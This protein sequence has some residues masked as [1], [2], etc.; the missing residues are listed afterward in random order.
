MDPIVEEEE[1]EYTEWDDFE[2]YV[3]PT[4]TGTWGTEVKYVLETGLSYLLAFYKKS[5]KEEHK[6]IYATVSEI[7]ESEKLV[8]LMD[9]D[10]NE[11]IF[12]YTEEDDTKYVVTENDIYVITEMYLVVPF[13][14]DKEDYKVDDEIDLVVSI[15]QEK[16]Y[17]DYIQ[18]DDISSSLIHSLDVYDQ[19]IRVKEIRETA[20]I[21]LELSKASDTLGIHDSLIITDL[22]H[23]PKC[24]HP[25]TNAFLKDYDDDNVLLSE[26]QDEDKGTYRETIS[27][28]YR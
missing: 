13:D 10:D 18:R 14:P 11:V 7:S 2:E 22:E 28:R 9:E 8:S 25:V 4:G 21:L 3:D 5:H 6:I 23:L 1:K 27:Q 26:L 20:G 15:T 24:I 17:S 16:I 19:P 12:E